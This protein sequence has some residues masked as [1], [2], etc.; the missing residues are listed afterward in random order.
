M[1]TNQKLYFTYHIIYLVLYKIHIELYQVFTKLKIHFSCE[2]DQ[3][4]FFYQNS[5]LQAPCDRCFDRALRDVYRRDEHKSVTPTLLSWSTGLRRSALF[6]FIIMVRSFELH[7]TC[8]KLQ[9]LKRVV[10]SQI[11]RRLSLTRSEYQTKGIPHF[12]KQHNNS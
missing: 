3:S 11:L 2:M 7:R 1:H 9:H 10:F 4:C 5:A 6:L 12:G 8:T